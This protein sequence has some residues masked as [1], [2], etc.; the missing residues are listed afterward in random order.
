MYQRS[1]TFRAEKLNE[2]ISVPLAELILKKLCCCV[3]S[4]FYAPNS[5]QILKNVFLKKMR[6]NILQALSKVEVL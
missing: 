2:N 4:L 1:N 6:D 3:V 5:L